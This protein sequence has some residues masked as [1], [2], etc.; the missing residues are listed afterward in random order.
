MQK[1][2]IVA[3]VVKETLHG[4]TV[5]TEAF[6]ITVTIVLIVARVHLH[7]KFQKHVVKNGKMQAY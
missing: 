3:N 7:R 4:E 1:R 6:V 5:L 2:K